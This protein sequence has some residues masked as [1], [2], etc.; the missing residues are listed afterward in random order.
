MIL[1]G[2]MLAL[3]GENV[4]FRGD[5]RIT[6]EKIAEIGEKLD[7][8][9]EEVLSVEGLLLLPGGVDPHVHFDDPGYTSREDFYCG[10]AAALSG[11][12]TTVIDMPCT[13]K[14][15][16]TGKN[17]LREKLGVVERKSLVDFG[18]FGG[19]CAQ[20]FD[21]ALSTAL[22][23][24]APHVCG[25]KVYFISGMKSFERLNLWQYRT[26]LEKT[27]QLGKPVLIHAEDYEYIHIATAIAARKG[28]SPYHYYSSRPEE[29]EILGVAPAIALAEMAEAPAHVVHIGTARAAT[30]LAYLGTPGRI[31]GE[32]APHY[33]AFDLEDFERI[34]SPLKV[35][36]PVKS[37]GNR[38]DL[39]KLL[40]GGTLSFVAS[41]HAPCTE[42]EKKTGSIWTDY[43]GI[44]G[45][46]TLLP[47]MISEGYLEGR[48]TL[49]RL[50]EVTSSR[51]AMR[52]GLLSKGAL[53]PG[54]DADITFVDLHR[55]WTVRGKEFLS[56]GKI[57][58]FEGKT[59]QGRVVRTML[60]GK[61]VY[62]EE[63]GI[64]AAPGSGRF[65]RPE[66][67]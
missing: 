22:E 52:Y 44:P 56:R 66:N 16:V 59:F 35:T 53:E 51:A 30:Y 9:G 60:R 42:K 65:L 46:G 13:S 2:G 47:F 37:P 57:T 14:P 27:R 50:V 28:D 39:W 26:L 67:A 25:F 17:N 5:L 6:G 21:L 63:K 62:Q 15:P 43:S 23:D 34:G 7:Y 4:P 49:R 55:T 18:L 19:V 29:A 48:L 45:T 32:T 8:P 12:I 1:R 40:A 41:D 11:G 3:P 36:P 61:T 64:C 20:S 31:T 33:L 10:S 58:P 24:L 38:E 54:K